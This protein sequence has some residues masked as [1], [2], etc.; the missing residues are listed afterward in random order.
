MVKVGGRPGGIFRARMIRAFVG[1][2]IG[3]CIGKKIGDKG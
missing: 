2:G 3:G 1:K